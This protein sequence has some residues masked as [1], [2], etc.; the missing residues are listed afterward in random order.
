MPSQ[1]LFSSR[2]LEVEIMPKKVS[3][4]TFESF[5]LE[6]SDV[7]FFLRPDRILGVFQVDHK[8]FQTGGNLDALKT[9]DNKAIGQL[10]EAEDECIQNISRIEESVAKIWPDIANLPRL[11]EHKVSS[12]SVI[13]VEKGIDRPTTQVEMMSLPIN[14]PQEKYFQNLPS[15][16][17]TSST[18]STPKNY[19]SMTT[20][21]GSKV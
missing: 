4:L 19:A 2:L 1:L 5:S 6:T 16:S 9:D 7:N 10:K 18:K 21:I 3:K 11:S 20:V 13:D 17:P 15:S 12:A 8:A 14:V